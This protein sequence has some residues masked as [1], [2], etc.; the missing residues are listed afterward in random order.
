MRFDALLRKWGL[1]PIFL[2][3]G[4]ASATASF[5]G[6]VASVVS[7]DTLVVLDVGRAIEVRLADIAAPQGSEYYAPVSRSLLAG[8]VGEHV[9]HVDVTG[10]AD[11]NRVY[12]RVKVG[13]L[14]VA[15]ELERPGAAWMSLKYAASTALEPYEIDAPRDRHA[16]PANT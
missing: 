16:V 12:A 13:E 2:A 14:D 6:K 8:I 15:T 1:T 11:D 10:E 7:G 5:D 9:V 4:L 3:C